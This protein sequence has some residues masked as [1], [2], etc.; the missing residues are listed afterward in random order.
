MN[1][2]PELQLGFS[3]A[4]NYLRRENKETLWSSM[5]KE[6]MKRKKPSFNESY[7]GYRTFS[8]LLEDAAQEGL[9]EL[10]KDARGRSYVVTRFGEELKDSNGH[11]TKPKRN[12]R[13]RGASRKTATGSELKQL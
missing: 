12:S 10:E 5:I 8:Q 11:T 3:D 4:E 2:I 9:I 6:T 7:H 1:P 13:R